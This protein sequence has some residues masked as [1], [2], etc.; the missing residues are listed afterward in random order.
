MAVKKIVSITRRKL[1]ALASGCTT[2]LVRTH[3]RRWERVAR[4]G[5]PPW[6]DRNVTIAGLIPAGS[7][8][9]DI[10]CGAQSLKGHL[11]ERCLYQPCDLVKSTPEVVLCD[12]NAGIFPRLSKHFDYVVCSGIFEYMRAPQE[13]LQQVTSLGSIT[14]L[15]YHPFRKGD[16]KWTR[17]VSNWVNHFT[18]TE[19]HAIFE[20]V[21]LQWK[22]VHG[23]GCA[24]RI[25]EIRNPK[26][27]V[28]SPNSG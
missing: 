10:G 3:R 13:F 20:Q 21:G 16:S 27:E 5:A 2:L 28:R 22:I 17:L 11:K 14:L 26:S 8:V 15:S 7:S 6:D 19:L 24:Q 23:K 1:N 25:Y 9:L 18:E 4:A 12:F